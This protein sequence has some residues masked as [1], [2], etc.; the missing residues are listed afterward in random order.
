MS[1][2]KIKMEVDTNPPSNFSTEAKRLL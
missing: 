2:I 1:S